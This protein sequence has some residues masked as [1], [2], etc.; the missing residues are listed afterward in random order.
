MKIRLPESLSLYVILAAIVAFLVWRGCGDPGPVVDPGRDAHIDS[1]GAVQAMGDTALEHADTTIVRSQADV[2]ITAALVDSLA[3]MHR[4]NDS[5]DA[6]V[7]ARTRQRNAERRLR[8]ADSTTTDSLL[9]VV[10]SMTQPRTG[11][12]LDTITVSPQELAADA[13]LSCETRYGYRLQELALSTQVI[14][15]CR[16]RTDT[17]L[18]ALVGFRDTTA[19]IRHFAAASDSLLRWER[20]R[21][22]PCRISLLITSVSC[23]TA[24]IGTAA[25]SFVGGLLAH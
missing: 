18:A 5:L 14:D 12:V 22:R 17:L 7:A 19:R 2:K 4:R 25:V 3:R 13:A 16:A 8:L 9:A 23:G 10:D 20:D 1:A 24:M 15:R 21:P 6:L 11:S